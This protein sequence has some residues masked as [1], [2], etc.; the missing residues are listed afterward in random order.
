[1][2]TSCRSCNGVIN[3]AWNFCPICGVKLK[4]PPIST[5]IG[6]QALIYFVSFFLAPFGIGYAFKYLKQSDSKA[7][8]V[9]AVSLALTISAVALMF[10]ITSSFMNAL[11]QPL[12]INGLF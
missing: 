8:I 12:T 4:E 1:M 7:K 6:K 2:E 9:G 5:S 11:Y 10:W 3:E